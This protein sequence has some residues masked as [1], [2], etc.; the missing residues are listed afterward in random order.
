M[1]TAGA[2]LYRRTLKLMT[3]HAGSPLQDRRELLHIGLIPLAILLAAWLQVYTGV[4]LSGEVVAD[5]FRGRAKPPPWV[6]LA[7]SELE[8]EAAQSAGGHGT[9][10]PTT[11]SFRSSRRPS[12]AAR[13][14]Q[15]RRRG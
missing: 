11:S 3:S 10:G 8:E 2:T 6:D 4:E 15:R 1:N 14:R 9:S 12:A 7:L 13:P 5:W